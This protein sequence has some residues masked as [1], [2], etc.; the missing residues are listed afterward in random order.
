MIVNETDS[1][2]SCSLQVSK[3]DVRDEEDRLGVQV[4]H[5]S[6]QGCIRFP[7]LRRL[8]QTAVF[9]CAR[10]QSYLLPQVKNTN[11]PEP[12][13]DE[14]E[15][16]FCIS[17]LKIPTAFTFSPL[18]ELLPVLVTKLPLSAL[19]IQQ[20]LVGDRNMFLVSS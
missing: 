2:L 17:G 5:A 10:E 20:G 18:P 8:P 7:D 16:R 15:N 14:L 3:V 12:L 6:E 19:K 13:E 4:P 9:P 11:D 1:H